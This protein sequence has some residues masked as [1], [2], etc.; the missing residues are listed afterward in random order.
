M[1]TQRAFPFSF[2]PVQRKGEETLAS[3]TDIRKALSYGES[4]LLLYPRLA[5]FD[6][7]KRYLVLLQNSNELRPTGG[8]IGSIGKLLFDEGKMRDFTIQ[9]V[10][11]VDGQLKG[12][13][14]PPGP[15]RDLLNQEHWYLRDSNWDPDFTQSGARAA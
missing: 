15:I 9:D 6:G 2:R 14:D 4:L 10:Y 13:I 1:L 3:L 7:P 8:F 5:G 11:A 12:H